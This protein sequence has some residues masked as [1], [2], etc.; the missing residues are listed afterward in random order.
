MVLNEGE[1]L[2]PLGNGVEVIV[3]KRHLF[4]TDTILLASFSSPKKNDLACDLGCGCGTVPLLWCRKPETTPKKTLGIEIQHE[5]YS[6]AQRS[7]EHNNLG[8]KISLLNADLRKLDGLVPFGTFSLVVCN[9]PYKAEGTG[10]VNPDSSLKT[11]R[12]ESE[13]TAD[14]IAA[15][16]SRLLQFGGRFCLC[17]RPERLPDITEALRKYNIEPKRLRFVQLNSK[18]APK[19]LLIEGRRG[20]KK[21][22]LRVEPALLLEDDSG[23]C[24]RE[25]LEIYGSFAYGYEK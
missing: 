4:W 13:C 3:S 18:K 23:G 19:L 25:M 10:I 8:E 2:E 7:V 6:M 11:A 1:R 21:G 9:P 12:H 14:D 17:Q 20:G 16:A 5:A 24:S 15:C 22:G